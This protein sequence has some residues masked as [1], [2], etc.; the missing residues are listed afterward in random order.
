MLANYIF[1]KV[2]NNNGILVFNLC[3]EILSG[4]VS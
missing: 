3:N 4:N 1:Q 2:P